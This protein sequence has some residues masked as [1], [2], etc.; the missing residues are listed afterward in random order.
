MAQE[1]PYISQIYHIS[2]NLCFPN[3]AISL[4]DSRK[5]SALPQTMTR[6]TTQPI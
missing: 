4:A 2:G 6:K 5:L 3:F 1:L